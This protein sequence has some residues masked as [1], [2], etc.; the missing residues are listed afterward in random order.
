MDESGTIDTGDLLGYFN[1]SGGTPDLDNAQ[2]V[3]LSGGDNWV[4]F[5]FAP[6]VGD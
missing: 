6:I 2:T 4:D 1:Y 5:E 3:T